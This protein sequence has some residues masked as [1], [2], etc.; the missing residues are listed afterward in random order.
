MS[1]RSAATSPS[2]FITLVRTGLIAAR[3]QLTEHC[4]PAK[5][6]WTLLGVT[7]D[8]AGV[9]FWNPSRATRG[10]L[11]NGAELRPVTNFRI[12]NGCGIG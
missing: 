8:V 3:R 11:S 9:G 6:E 4:P 7:V 5:A 10:A 2:S 12:V 1:A